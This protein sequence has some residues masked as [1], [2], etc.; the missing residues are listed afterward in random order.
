M[1]DGRAARGRFIVVEGG[2]GS[3]KGGVI[4]ALSARLTAADHDLLVTR[5]PGGTDEGL[6]LRELLLSAEGAVW[7]QGAELLLM[8]AA[9]IQHVKRVIAPALAAGRIVLCDRFVG[10]T[11][12]YQGAGRGISES[13]IRGL[14]RDLVDDL[15]PDITVLLDVDPRVG[16]ARSRARLSDAE[17]D[18]GRFEDLDIGFHDR[19]R[20]GFLDQAQHDVE[21]TLVIDAARPADQVRA[22][23]ITQVL[24]RLDLLPS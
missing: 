15:W 6:K 11:L 21:R 13:L 17:L 7:D 3:G 22:D 12:A 16:L 18:E 8:T 9:R 10:S 23:A 4:E 24:A 1:A 5:E 19:V 2:D 20:G 14:H